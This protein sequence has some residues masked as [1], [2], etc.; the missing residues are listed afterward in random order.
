MDTCESERGISS[1]SPS[2]L[3]LP[4]AAGKVSSSSS[5]VVDIDGTVGGDGVDGA[6]PAASSAGPCPPSFRITSSVCTTFPI[7][8]GTSICMED[9]TREA[10]LPHANGNVV[11]QLKISGDKGAVPRLR[12]CPRL[13]HAPSWCCALRSSSWVWAVGGI[14]QRPRQSLASVPAPL[15]L[16]LPLLVFPAGW[17]GWRW[18]VVLFSP[19]LLVQLS[20]NRTGTRA[21]GLKRAQGILGQY[22]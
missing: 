17:R 16:P 21:P 19:P 3:A 10:R 11:S 1:R 13:A 20:W 15:P 14:A 22:I 2:G 8:Y 7:F 4:P 6:S 5:S 12:P 9:H 18:V